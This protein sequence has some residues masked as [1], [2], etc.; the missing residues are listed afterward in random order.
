[1]KTFDFSRESYFSISS[2]SEYFTMY[3][4]PHLSDFEFHYVTDLKKQTNW[5][6]TMENSMEVP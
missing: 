2:T 3:F 5:Y 6:S 4:S 1:M